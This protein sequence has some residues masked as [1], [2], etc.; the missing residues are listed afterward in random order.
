[1]SHPVHTWYTQCVTF[2]SFPSEDWERIYIIFGMVMIYLL[3]LMVI[4]L[5]Y[6]VILYTILDKSRNGMYSQKIS[7]VKWMQLPYLIKVFFPNLCCWH[8]ISKVT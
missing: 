8:V 7:Q 1:M 3:P 2:G 6:S 4:V 5:T